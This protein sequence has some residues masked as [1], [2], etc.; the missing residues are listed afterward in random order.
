MRELSDDRPSDDRRG[1][2]KADP[3]GVGDT[4]LRSCL[5]RGAAFAWR[6]FERDWL[7]SGDS[8]EEVVEPARRGPWCHR[9]GGSIGPGENAS[10][11][12]ACRGRPAVGDAVVRLGEFSG[13]LRRMVLELKYGARPEVAEDLGREL[14]EAIAR[15]AMPD[16]ASTVVTAVPGASW[17][18]WH[19]GVDHAW[20]LARV[21]G[22]SLHLPAVKLLAHS[23]APPRSGREATERPGRTLRHRRDWPAGSMVGLRLLLLDDVLTTG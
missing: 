14:A 21:V 1:L 4:T 23:G 17:R 5:R 19:R 13:D 6:A 10:P 16:P 11:C 18:V 2:P 12:V 9:C 3:E 7:G 22:H 20:E 8:A 15:E